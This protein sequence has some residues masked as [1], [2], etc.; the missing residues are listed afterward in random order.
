MLHPHCKLIYSV[1]WLIISQRT[2]KIQTEKKKKLNNFKNGQTRLGITTDTKHDTNNN[3]INENGRRRVIW[4]WGC[5]H[6]WVLFKRTK[7]RLLCELKV[8]KDQ[9][10]FTF[11]LFLSLKKVPILF[12]FGPPEVNMV[13]DFCIRTILA[14]CELY[15]RPTFKGSEII[16][17][18]DIKTKNQVNRAQHPETDQVWKHPETQTHFFPQSDLFKL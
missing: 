4:D 13:S 10:L 14:E 8:K 12:F 3:N 2:E 7:L 5:F 16:S 6:S 9:V 17:S 15:S 11:T 1:V 18:V